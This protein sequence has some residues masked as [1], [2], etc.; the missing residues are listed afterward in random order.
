[1]KLGEG[2]LE[3]NTYLKREGCWEIAHIDTP[4]EGVSKKAPKFNTYYLNGPISL[5]TTLLLYSY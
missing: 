4:G 5:N 2:V 1:M 3:F